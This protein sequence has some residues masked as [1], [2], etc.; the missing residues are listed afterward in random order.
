MTLDLNT[1]SQLNASKGKAQIKTVRALGEWEGGMATVM[2]VRNHQFRA[3]EPA[4]L[5]GKDEA[6]TPMELVAGA[7]NACVTVVIATVANELGLD[8]KDIRTESAAD[9]DVRGFH[10]TADVSP[11]F[12]NYRLTIALTTDA[13]R[14][15]LDVLRERAEKRCPAVNLVRD[16]GA[17]VEVVWN[18]SASRG[19]K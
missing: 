12:C 14:E 11:H 13:P 18:I 16:S 6:A 9:I 10:G 19:Q 3:D 2:T 5:G 17:T 15:L 7:V 8:I 4:Y 1:D